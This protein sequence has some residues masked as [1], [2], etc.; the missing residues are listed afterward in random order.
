MFTDRKPQQDYNVSLSKLVY[1]FGAVSIQIPTVFL[2]ETDR[3]SLNFIWKCKQPTD[4][5]L[6]KVWEM[7]SYL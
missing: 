3:S 7:L 4:K 6:Y 2:I 5:N 1:K